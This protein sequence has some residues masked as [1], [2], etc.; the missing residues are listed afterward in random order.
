[1]HVSCAAWLPIKGESALG[2]VLTDPKRGVPNEILGARPPDSL[3]YAD[4]DDG[5]DG[6]GTDDPHG[7]DDHENRE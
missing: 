1:M 3:I 6:R 4:E 5:E 7:P 2:V